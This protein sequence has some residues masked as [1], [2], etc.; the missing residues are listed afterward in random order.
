[1]EAA[2]IMQV[3]Q[4]PNDKRKQVFCV[5]SILLTRYKVQTQE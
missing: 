2:Y 1:M 3:G 5:K 4:R